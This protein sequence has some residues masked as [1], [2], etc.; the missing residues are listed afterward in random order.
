MDK[1]FGIDAE[2]RPMLSLSHAE[3]RH[4]LFLNQK[5]T[6]DSFLEHGAISRA[7]HEKSLHDLR[8][9]MNETEDDDT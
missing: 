8:V 6:L 4:Q 3:K 2:E 7:Q 9:K 1:W 5:T